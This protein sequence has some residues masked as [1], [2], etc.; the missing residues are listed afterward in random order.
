MRQNKNALFGTLEWIALTG[1]R[2]R[3]RARLAPGKSQGGGLRDTSTRA[4]D[5]MM[6]QAGREEFY[7]GG[8]LQLLPSAG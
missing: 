5:C 8:S 1:G 7:I 6:S 3:P 2:K 4:T